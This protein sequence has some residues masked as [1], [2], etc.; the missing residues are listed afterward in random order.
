MFQMEQ[1]PPARDKIQALTQKVENLEAII[2]IKA[3]YERLVE[4]II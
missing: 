3:E 2:D 4:S 1:L